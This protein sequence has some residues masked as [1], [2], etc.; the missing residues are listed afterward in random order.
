M[1]ATVFLYAGLAVASSAAIAL[2]AR[3]REEFSRNAI[4][5]SATTGVIWAAN[6]AL[7]PLAGVGIAAMQHAYD[8]L[9][10]PTLPASIWAEVPAPL[11]VVLAILAKDFADY[12]CHRALH[13]RWL[14]PIHAVHHSDT[15]VN[16]LTTFRVHALEAVTMVAFYIV[17]LSWLGLPPVL[18]A[19][20]TFV[21]VAHNMYVHLNVDIEHGPLRH[22]IASPRFHRWHHADEPEIYGKNLANIF[23]F[24]DVMFGTYRVPG[25]CTAR[26][27]LR[28]DGVPATDPIALLAHPFRAWLRMLA[29]PAAP[30]AMRPPAQA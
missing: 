10:V 2:V 15:H 16:A 24:F 4:A 5:N 18:G 9:H 11:L 26:M 17:L 19:V 21:A 28:A 3:R 12:W 25:R 8:A 7:A 20:A 23:P 29:P 14:W 1:G 6:L 30:E 27:G 13:M 22:V